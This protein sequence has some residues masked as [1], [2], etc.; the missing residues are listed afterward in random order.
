MPE[1]PAWNE[2]IREMDKQPDEKKASWLNQKQQQTLNNISNLRKGSNVIFYASSFL[3]KPMVPAY[4][5][6]I[7]LEEINGFMSALHGMNWDKG[8]TLILHTPGGQAAATETL[9][10]YLHSKFDYIEV[11]IPTYAMSA[12]TMISLAANK[13]IMGKQSQLGPIDPQIGLGGR[14]VP[15]GAIHQQFERARK[16][17]SEDIKQ[18]HLWAPVLQTLGPSL[19]QE[20][21]N[22]LEYGEQMVTKWLKDRMFAGQ[23]NAEELAEKTAKYFNDTEEH[24]IHGHR[25]DR[26]EALKQ[27]LN[28]ENL[29]DSQDLQDEV[30]TSYHLMT[31]LFERSP[32]TKIVITNHD[33]IWVKNVVQ[34]LAAKPQ[35]A[36]IQRPQEIKTRP[37]QPKHRRRK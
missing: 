19:L 32:T 3:Q 23:N 16:E 4:D 22:V 5:I 31:I 12:G 17:L 27:Q 18:A 10:E 25:I 9:V 28:I 29:E 24:K 14:S 26:E 8:L 2:F 21:K 11:I 30:L 37:K 20:S 1:K 35:P 34:S 15:A 13:I 6:Q 7:T 33:K 36:S